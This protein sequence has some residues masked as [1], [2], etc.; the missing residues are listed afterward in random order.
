MLN[1]RKAIAGE[2]HKQARVNFPRR[3]VEVKGI[4]DLYQADLVEMIPFSKI[5]KNHKYILTIINCFTKFALAIPLK[6]KTADAVEQALAKVLKTHS[7]RNLQTDKGSEFFNY[8]VKKLLN[9]YGI[10]HYFTHSEKKAVFVER[11]NKTLKNRMWRL[12]S[13]RGNYKWLDILPKLVN[14][15]NNGVHRTIGMKPNQ[16][17][18]SNEKAVLLRIV[19]QR[20]KYANKPKFSVGDSV[21][22]SRL[23]KTFGKG[24]HPRWSNEIYKIHLIQNTAP[25][26]YILKDF[27]NNSIQGCFYEQELS[28]SAYKDC[29]LIEKV[30]KRRGDELLVRWLGFDKAHDSWIHKKDL[31]KKNENS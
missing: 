20:R 6:C 21:R 14:E 16:V 28:K 3:H 2:L 11:F 13:E 5:N 30:I 23:P 22:I 18:E 27:E 17:N 19:S 7:M 9:M 24:Y 29:Y 4:N 1:I 26:T 31:I 12:F 8:K 15:Y 10:N 25:I